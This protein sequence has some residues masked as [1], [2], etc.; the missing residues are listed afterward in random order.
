MSITP[1]VDF[2]V[3]KK[4]G[5]YDGRRTLMQH[6]NIIATPNRLI[7]NVIFTQDA[8]EKLGGGSADNSQYREVDKPINP[9]NIKKQAK[10]FG[11][12]AHNIGV[13]GKDLKDSWK[14][15]MSEFKALKSREKFH[16]LFHEIA[17]E[18]QN[19]E[20]FEDGVLG[21][22]ENNDNSMN[23]PVSMIQEFK[24]G[25]FANAKIIL[26]DGREIKLFIQKGKKNLKSVLNR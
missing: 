5:F 18:S 19:I 24:L 14:E 22:A 15:M 25:W 12:A 8:L 10:A 1:N 4:A 6:G 7:I 21:V 2:F 11:D 20:E 9:F 13:A 23:I 16:D 17:A 3:A 26:T